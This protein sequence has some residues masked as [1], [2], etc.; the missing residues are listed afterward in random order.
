MPRRRRA[1]VCGRLR[2]AARGGVGDGSG[3]R[4][5]GVVWGDRFMGTAGI[6][7]TAYDGGTRHCSF[8]HNK[9]VYTLADVCSG[10]VL[11]VWFVR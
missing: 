4:I 1:A 6:V 7:G 10:S 5:G 3:A 2:G 9:N 11:G 8:L